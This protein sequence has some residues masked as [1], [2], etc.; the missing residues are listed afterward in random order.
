[1]RKTKR[2]S[3]LFSFLAVIIGLSVT[4]IL[5]HSESTCASVSTQKIKVIIE[6]DEVNFLDQEPVIIKNRVMVPL[7]AVFQHKYVQAEVKWE[8]LNQSITAT[9]RT[10]R[11]VVFKIGNHEYQII[12]RGEIE[13]RYSDAVPVIENGRT[14]LPLRALAEA[15]N[16]QVDWSETKKRVEIKEKQGNSLSDRELMSPEEWA[17]YLKTGGQSVKDPCKYT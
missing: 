17:E 1:M 8:P 14:L 4:A 3:L 7:R 13:T 2:S 12:T 5:V 11:K 15:F 6:L 9:D 10:G 16:F